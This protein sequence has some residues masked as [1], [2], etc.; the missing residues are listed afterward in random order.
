MDNL[1]NIY[2]PFFSIKCNG[3][4]I[5]NYINDKIIRFEFNEDY[6]KDNIF[7]IILDNSDLKLTDDTSLD[8]GK[9]I[10]CKFGYLDRFTEYIDAE[11]K[12]IEGFLQIK[13][14]AY[15]IGKG[16][17]ILNSNKNVSSPENIAED[18]KY[19]VRS[20]DTLNKISKMFDLKDWKNLYEINKKIIGSNPNKIEPGMSLQIPNFKNKYDSNYSDTI[21]EEN[22]LGI[23]SKVWEK[24]TYS[25]IAYDIAIQMNLIPDITTTK[26]YFDS[27][28]QS[29]ETNIGFLKRIGAKIGF[30]PKITGKILTFSKIDFSQKSKYLITYYIDGAGELLEFD[31]KIKTKEKSSAASSTSLSTEEKDTLSMKSLKTDTT[32]L[33][34]F[35]WAVNGV[36]GTVE[37]ITGVNE[38]LSN[39]DLSGS[40]KLDDEFS[41]TE[42]SM[43]DT[44]TGTIT[45]DCSCVGIP[46][47]RANTV[48][49]VQ[50]VGKRW[51]GNWFVK[52]V[53]HSIDS[54]G[55]STKVENFR[56]ALGEAVAPVESS[57]NNS[58]GSD[59]NSNSNS[60]SNSDAK[61]QIGDYT[62]VDGITGE[63]TI[64]D[65]VNILIDKYL[66]KETGK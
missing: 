8:I 19:T 36:T 50:G 53:T 45:A 2:D 10:S 38:N 12:D 51:S 59:F 21:I 3:F 55:Y 4:S 1:R 39:S 5:P 56:N 40:S 24:K 65:K 63:Q 28:P 30:H 57:Q 13:L 54:N 46:E 17:T 41:D 32:K 64:M 60:N 61:N 20:G 66:N 29:N 18:R 62:L 31:P 47:I 11:I 7:T 26:Q 14:T 44:E 58:I 9:I 48:M 22:V 49:T 15:S 27:V 37:K 33:G 42:T 23:K 34:A 16:Y 43:E 35:S 25:Q 6:K 52:N